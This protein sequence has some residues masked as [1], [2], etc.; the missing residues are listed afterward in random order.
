MKKLLIATLLFFS[1]IT[2]EAQGVYS[3]IQEKASSRF[4]ATFI[5]KIEKS[6]TQYS[7]ELISGRLLNTSKKYSK[8]S[9]KWHKNDFLCLILDGQRNVLDTLIIRHPLKQRLE[10]INDDGSFSTRIVEKTEKVVPLRFQYT[11][12]MKFLRM[13]KVGENRELLQ[14]NTIEI[15]QAF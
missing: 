3:G 10:F 4:L 11:S 14:L 15:P 8:F 9:H 2:V 12:E 5:L 6:G 1:F 13:V 7:T